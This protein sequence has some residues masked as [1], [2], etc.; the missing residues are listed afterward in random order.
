MVIFV[1]L[2]KVT[3]PITMQINEAMLL[4]SPFKPMLQIR[5]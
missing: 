1:L 4:A 5:C 3:D 2:L